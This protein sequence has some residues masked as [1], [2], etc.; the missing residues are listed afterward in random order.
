MRWY[1][2]KMEVDDLTA[3]DDLKAKLLAMTDTPDRGGKGRTH[4]GCPCPA[5]RCTRS[6]PE[7]RS[8]EEK[9][10]STSRKAAGHAGCLSGRV[11]AGLQHPCIWA[12]EWAAPKAA[13]PPCTQPKA[14]PTAPLPLWQRAGLI[15]SM[16][17]WTAPRGGELQS[18]CRRPLSGNGIQRHRQHRGCRP[19]G[20]Q[21]QDHLHR[22]PDAGKQGL[23]NSP[24]CTGQRSCRGGRLSGI[25]QRVRA[26]VPAAP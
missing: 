7:H 4:D 18:G 3:P 15:S 13:R 10:P 12:S 22:Q 9:S 23:R 5:D 2:Y 8:Q 14:L 19:C 16:P 17:R 24:Q 20:G 6:T 25:Q 26:P 1:E 21:C 11:R